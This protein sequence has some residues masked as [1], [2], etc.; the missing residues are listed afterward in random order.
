M[1]KVFICWKSST[2]KQF[3]K[4][5]YMTSLDESGG[6]SFEGQLKVDFGCLSV[7]FMQQLIEKYMECVTLEGNLRCY[8]VK[9]LFRP[10]ITGFTLREAI[11]HGYNTA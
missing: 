2:N 10:R 9:S 1:C 8:S 4:M 5:L 6:G 3:K 7:K 11:F